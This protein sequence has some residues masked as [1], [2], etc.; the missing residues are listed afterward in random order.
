MRADFFTFN[1]EG[2]NVTNDFRYKFELK[3]VYE[4][5]N[6]RK[7]SPAAKSGLQVGDII[8]KINRAPV[9]HYSLQK[10]NE[11]FKSEDEKTFYLEI[12]RNTRILKFSFQLIDDL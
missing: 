6:I 5:A 12:E 8:I 11:L 3:P 2:K 1:S 7:N 9:Y 10:L 4:I